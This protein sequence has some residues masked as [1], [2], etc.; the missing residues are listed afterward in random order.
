MKRVLLF[1]LLIFYTWGYAGV[2]CNDENKIVSNSLDILSELTKEL[3][4]MEKNPEIKKINSIIN[5]VD[6]LCS[7]TILDSVHK[8]IN[9]IISLTE[10]TQSMDQFF[11]SVTSQIKVFL[12]EIVIDEFRFRTL[13]AVQHQ[14]GFLNRNLPDLE[15]LISSAEYATFN[16]E[17]SRTKTRLVNRQ[18]DILSLTADENEKL[19]CWL[20]IGR[21]LNEIDISQ[22]EKGDQIIQRSPYGL[23]IKPGIILNKLK[24]INENEKNTEIKEFSNNILF[25]IEN[26][27]SKYEAVNDTIIY[28]YKSQRKP[29]EK[30]PEVEALQFF[31]KA[32]LSEDNNE[33]ILLYGE[34]IKNDSS[35]TAAYYNRGITYYMTG[36]YQ[37]AIR[38]FKCVIQLDS[39]Y[40]TSF[41]N[42]G[43]SYFKLDNYKE[44]INQLSKALNKGEKDLIIFTTRGLCYQKLKN[45]DEAI[46]DYSKAV[47]IDS[48]SFMAYSNR[49]E[50]YKH[51]KMTN[52]V[53]NDY[54]KLIELKPDN[55]TL[56][57][58]I[59]CI[60]FNKRD[61]KQAVRYW[62]EGLEVNPKDPN[63]AASLPRAKKYLEGKR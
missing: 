31:N 45:Y 9:E 37:E 30:K 57:Y 15:R 47:E 28:E 21:M 5:N 59:G 50:C 62:E 63:I 51:L 39:T 13:V 17:L 25:Q 36:D 23:M 52:K 2:L 32:F 26:A 7:G 12:P 14:L 19:R 61:W 43:L 34:A 46:K 35:F 40:T 29:G 10:K 1:L 22:S 33:R 11:P 6:L 49:A 4:Y 54:K 55:S 3:S 27:S 56:Y 60:Y 53:I 58:N 42:L 41:T 18:I 48:N 44:S 38:D 24:E 20:A 16:E 8:D